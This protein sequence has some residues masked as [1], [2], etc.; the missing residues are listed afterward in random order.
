[1]DIDCQFNGDGCGANEKQIANEKDGREM[2]MQSLSD[3]GHESTASLSKST[4][5]Q[6]SECGSTDSDQYDSIINEEY[7][8]DDIGVRDKINTFYDLVVVI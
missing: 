8:A 6:E 4:S 7:I 3:E 2:K 5:K 1:M